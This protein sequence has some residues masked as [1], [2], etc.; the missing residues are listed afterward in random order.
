MRPSATKA[1]PVVV[2]PFHFS[3]VPCDVTT[4][5]ERGGSGQKC[6]A[7]LAKRSDD[8]WFVVSRSGSYLGVLEEGSDYW[9]VRVIP[10]TGAIPSTGIPLPNR[11][12]TG[13]THTGALAAAF[14]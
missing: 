6:T 5:Y 3:L 10:S 9:S 12:Y 1:T 13:E 7:T 8:S 4:T 11:I 14:T 2:G